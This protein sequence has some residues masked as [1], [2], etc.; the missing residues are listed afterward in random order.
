MPFQN[1]ACR[2]TLGAHIAAARQADSAAGN[3]ASK[4]DNGL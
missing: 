2:A 1:H 3:A 4:A